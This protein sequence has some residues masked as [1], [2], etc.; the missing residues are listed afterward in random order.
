[1]ERKKLGIAIVGLGGAVG[2]TIVAGIELLREGAIRND[3][4]PL[5]SLDKGLTEDL[6]AYT[7]LAVGGWDI[8]GANLAEAASEH[9]VLTHK[10]FLAV[11]EE[12][13][14]LKPWPAV[15]NRDFLSNIEGENKVFGIT[16]RESI[17]KICKDLRSFKDTCQK[18]VVINLAS[19]E[20][21]VSERDEIFASLAAFDKALFENS[22]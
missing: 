15:C 2:T 21:P 1:M 11:E 9:D 4:L 14:L 3:G 18:M 5:D 19:T 7:D 16:H 22:A 17:E 13:S 12:L 10:Q 8:N 20:K 6:A